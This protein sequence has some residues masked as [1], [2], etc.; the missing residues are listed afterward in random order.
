MQKVVIVDDE[1]GALSVISRMVS[2]FF[3]FNIVGEFTDADQLVEKIATLRP[4]VLFLDI[5]LGDKSG[6]EIAKELYHA[7]FN[8]KIVI[9]SA[10]Q[11]YAIQ[12]F[13]YNIIDYILKPVSRERLNRCIQKLKKPA[14]EAM[15]R[16]KENNVSG[17]D[18][19]TVRF[20]TKN[21]F[22]LINPI[23]IVCLEADQMYTKMVLAKQTDHFLAQNM[24]KILSKIDQSNFLRISR[25]IVINLKYLR[26]VNRTQRKCMMFDGIEEYELLI[27]KSGM[28]VLD[29]YFDKKA[30]SD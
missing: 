19:N 24:G 2:D 15:E 22:I 30:L 28:K 8:T 23:E 26:E 20:K 4:D 27:T 12:A 5:H 11:E 21:G 14:I 10:H 17:L 1:P 6:M 16:D 13:E 9:V 3:D 7:R 29:E 25:S 18:D